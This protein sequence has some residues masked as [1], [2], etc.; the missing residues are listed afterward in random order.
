[1]ARIT[2][3]SINK[4]LKEYGWKCVSDTYQNLDSELHFQC[5]EGHDVYSTWKKIR[6]RRECPICAANEYTNMDTKVVPK[7]GK[8]RVFALDQSTHTTGWCIIDDGALTKYG[9]FNA[10]A[11]D[12]AERAH[13]LRMWYC[14][15]LATWKPDHCALE[16]IQYQDEVAGGPKM[17]VTVF[18]ALARV[19]G[20]LMEA[21]F[22]AKI[23]FEICPTN[24]WRHAIGVKGRS[25]V[26]KKRSMQLKIKEWYDVSV[27]DDIA[28]AIGIGKYVADKV[29]SMGKT[30]QW[31][32]V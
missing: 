20:V 16:G 8:I 13:K 14:S 27:V 15:M 17:G 2:I 12:E 5:D 31:D 11:G 10:G 3:E 21:C 9:T 1:M 29:S 19:Q 30:E 25:R 24:T 6:S 28:D 18:Q 32:F 22:A 7:K 23:P 26:D 4:E